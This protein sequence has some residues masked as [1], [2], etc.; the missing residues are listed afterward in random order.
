MA[1]PLLTF[2][3]PSTPGR[4][5]ANSTNVFAWYKAGN[6]YTLP[7]VYEL[8]GSNIDLWLD[9]SYYDHHAVGAGATRPTLDTI[10]THICGDI[11][12]P[13]IK[14]TGITPNFDYVQTPVIPE[15]FL[16]FNPIQRIGIHLGFRT[17]FLQTDATLFSI[18]NTGLNRD[19]ISISLTNSG[20][21]GRITVLVDCG[22]EVV[23]TTYTLPA[24]L[25]YNDNQVHSI[26]MTYN[27]NLTLESWKLVVDGAITPLDLPSEGAIAASK[28]ITVG[29]YF[30]NSTYS[31]RG[32]I[33]EVIGQLQSSESQ[34]QNI[35]DYLQRRWCSN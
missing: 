26:S 34:R 7:P 22:D 33:V 5:P 28:I 6:H 3:T 17:T 31:Y 1:I 35:Y 21:V 2:H 15:E 18:H 24:P 32:D 16:S 10:N 23:P 12:L 8:T 27:A 13:V 20:V 9:Q 14:F 19:G 4:G 25:V 29:Q 30:N 11:E